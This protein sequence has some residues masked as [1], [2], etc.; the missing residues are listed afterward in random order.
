MGSDCELIG[1]AFAVS[2]PV[3]EFGVSRS[4]ELGVMSNQT[5][6]I[7]FF[8][9]FFKNCICFPVGIVQYF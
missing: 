2:L 5:D 1:G 6:Q 9:L 7:A 3:L 4:W 8:W